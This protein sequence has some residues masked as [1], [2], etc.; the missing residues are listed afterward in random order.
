M[1]ES[2]IDL[3]KMNQDNNGVAQKRPYTKPAIIHEFELEVHAGSP[4]PS[5]PMDLLS[6]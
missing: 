4:I 2:K 1:C 6:I 3:G 5:D